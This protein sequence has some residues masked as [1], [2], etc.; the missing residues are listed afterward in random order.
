MKTLLKNAW[1]L[2]AEHIFEKGN[3]LVI[4]ERIAVVG[5]SEGT[6]A[7]A[8]IDLNNCTLTP[9]FIDSHV[10][11]CTDGGPR[12]EMLTEWARNGVTTVRDLGLLDSYDLQEYI[13]WVDKH[14]ADPRFPHVITAGKCIDIENGYGVGPDPTKV[15]GIIVQ[16]PEEAA[17][18]VTTEFKAGVKCIKIGIAD[19]NGPGGPRNKLPAVYI[20]AICDRAREH[21][22]PVTAH[23]VEVGDFET[24]FRNGIADA[25][26]TPGDK[27]I[28]KELLCETI[29]N[30]L[31]YVT[32]IG[33]VSNIELPSQMPED[34]KQHIKT[35][36]TAKETVVKRNLKAIFDCGGLISLGTDVVDGDIKK[37][38]IPVTEMKQ[39]QDVGIPFADI[40]KMATINGA[41]VCC[42]AQNEGS[43]EAGK[44]A[45]LCAFRGRPENNFDGFAKPCF[46]MNR[47]IILREE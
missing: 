2:D 16:N 20:K 38:C 1:L 35:M 30:G 36:L 33:D 42:T 14:N 4:D 25:A 19:D 9:G 32:T 22:I 24:L 17:E 43:I 27:D 44:L 10:H 13:T 21:E 12:E 8:V 45:N 31:S 18:A 37:A 23:N 28:P 3:V 46:V 26:H 47:G 34:I 5:C 11:V 15:C 29:E 6:E 39:L 7:D 41:I 40:I